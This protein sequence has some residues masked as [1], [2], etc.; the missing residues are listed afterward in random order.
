M[1]A[2]IALVCAFSLAG[3]TPA[4]AVTSASKG[5]VIAFTRADLN[6]DGAVNFEDLILGMEYLKGR[7][8]LA[9]IEAFDVINDGEINHGDLLGLEHIASAPK[10]SGFL[11]ER[12]VIVRGD[13]DGDGK[14]NSND[15][16]L[17]EAYLE[18]WGRIWDT[19]LDAADLD[20][21]GVIDSRDMA[22]LDNMVASEG[23]EKPAVSRAG[24]SK[25]SPA[26][27]G[28]SF[29]SG[30]AVE[31]AGS[32]TFSGV[33]QRDGKDGERR[34]PIV[35]DYLPP[36][37]KRDAKQS[38]KDSEH[39]G[40]GTAGSK[41][42]VSS[43]KKSSSVKSRLQISGQPKQPQTTSRGTLSTTDSDKQAQRKAQSAKKPPMKSARRAL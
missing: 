38:D 5:E 23:E 32:L 6:D 42:S 15:A 24:S 12:M 21:N 8:K 33:T 26:G 10:G 28:L 40:Y 4:D 7:G 37:Y 25:R 9:V 29:S 22:R 1:P 11:P 3:A 30:E 17:L 41:R 35:I 16:R 13:L 20:D 31:T 27:V 19:A 18:Q 39:L 36:N 14:I 2:V 43:S 34:N